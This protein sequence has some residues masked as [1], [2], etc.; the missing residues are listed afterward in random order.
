MHKEKVI[1]YFSITQPMV[2]LM[3]FIHVHMI[4]FL[5][6]LLRTR[7]ESCAAPGTKACREKMRRDR[8]NDRC[9]QHATYFLIHAAS[10]IDAL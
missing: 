3:F 5:H 2:D 7:V 8:L 6:L 1:N 9:A 10:Q 4:K